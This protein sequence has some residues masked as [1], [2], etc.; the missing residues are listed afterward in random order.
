MPVKANPYHLPGIDLGAWAERNTL[1][2]KYLPRIATARGVEREKLVCKFA[3]KLF[4]SWAKRR[5]DLVR[6]EAD[7]E[8][9]RSEQATYFSMMVMPSFDGVELDQSETK[10]VDVTITGCKKKWLARAIERVAPVEVVSKPEDAN[11]PAPAQPTAVASGVNGFDRR[12][13]V[14]SYIEEVFRQK[15][16]RI[17]RTDIWKHARY[18]TRTEFER[19]QRKSPRATKTAN[20]RFTTVLNEK[21]HLK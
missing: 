10:A 21:P 17:T 15:N 20:E 12:K 16:R 18:K 6:E 5:L 14:D 13:A 11:E 3:G 9:F 7:I 8:R 1:G 4:D 2:G 19:W